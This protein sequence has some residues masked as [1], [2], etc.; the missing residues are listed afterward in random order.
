M[1]TEIFTTF[2][3]TGGKIEM[4]YLHNIWRRAVKNRQYSNII[5]RIFNDHVI[6][7]LSINNDAIV[8]TVYQFN[9]RDI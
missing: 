7:R 1:G 2:I 9:I 8:D 5:V 4:Y 6:Y 3:G